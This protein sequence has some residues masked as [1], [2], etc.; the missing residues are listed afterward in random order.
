M[1][2]SYTE[3]SGEQSSSLIPNLFRM[4]TIFFP[5]SFKVGV[6]PEATYRLIPKLTYSYVSHKIVFHIPSRRVR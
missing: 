2:K 3:S 6:E 4:V 1:K 5:F